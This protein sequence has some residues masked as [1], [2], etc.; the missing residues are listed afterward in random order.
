MIPKSGFRFS[1]KITLKCKSARKSHRDRLNDR[2]P[3]LPAA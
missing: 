3:A 1:E 2:R